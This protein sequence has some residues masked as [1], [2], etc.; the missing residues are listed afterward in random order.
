MAHRSSH[1]PFV[2]EKQ[3]SHRPARFAQRVKEE[4]SQLIPGSIRDPR[5][6]GIAFVTL[7][8]VEVTP[9][10]RNGTVRFALMAESD[11]K[12]AKEVEEALNHSSSFLRHQLMK[13]INT[14]VTPQL[15]FKYDKGLTNTLQIDSLLKQVANDPPVIHDSEN[16]DDE[17]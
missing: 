1:K 2:P 13:R 12:R 11:Q 9:D 5:M 17:E 15:H 8:S 14:K 10:L 7:T 4:L 3:P 16:D 6:E